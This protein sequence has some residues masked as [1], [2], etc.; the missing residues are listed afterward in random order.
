MK[1]A[2][3]L[4]RTIFGLEENELKSLNTEKLLGL[5][6]GVRAILGTTKSL[7][8]SKVDVFSD[9]IRPYMN[10]SSADHG[11]DGVVAC[12]YI[13]AKKCFRPLKKI[14]LLLIWK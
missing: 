11:G 14:W 4:I 2:L 8:S 7:H 13:F 9:M 12:S 1:P 10:S 5:N 6:E 3:E